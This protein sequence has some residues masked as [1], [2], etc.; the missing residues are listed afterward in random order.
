MKRAQTLVA[1]AILLAGCAA[2]AQTETASPPPTQVPVE[3][4]TPTSVPVVVATEPALAATP[5]ATEVEL[6]PSP[7]PTPMLNDQNPAVVSEAGT[8]LQPVGRIAPFAHSRWSSVFVPNPN[9]TEIFSTYEP[10]TPS[11]DL[12]VQLAQDGPTIC[13]GAAQ[14]ALGVLSPDN[15]TV[16]P[17]EPAG[18]LPLNVTSV[19]TGPDG[20]ALLWSDCGDTSGLAIAD[21]ADD[22]DFSN[23]RIID[24]A[25]TMSVLGR[26]EWII[27][28]TEAFG[29]GTYLVLPQ[30]AVRAPA[31]PGVRHI[32]IHVESGT[33]VDD[34]P[35]DWVTTTGRYGQV[36][37]TA[38]YEV[39]IGGEPVEA[40]TGPTYRAIGEPWP[41]ER[42]RV[43]LFGPNGAAMMTANRWDDDDLV[44]SA[45][46]I[47][48]MTDFVWSPFG[49]TFFVSSP[50]GTWLNG[51]DLML[52]AGGGLQMS[53]DGSTL[54]V[55]A[56]DGWH[57]LTFERLDLSDDADYE[58][59]ITPWT[60]LTSA[61]LGP[62]RIDMTVSE[63]ADVFGRELT[64]DA[65]GD[66][67]R[68]DE[69]VWVVEEVHPGVRILGSSTGDDAVITLIYASGPWLT[70]SGIQIGMTR[71]QVMETFPDQI[72]AR[73]HEYINGEY[74]TF[75]P[76]DP[77][78]PN[79]VQFVTGEDDRV[80]EIKVG[81]RGW[82][83]AVE[84]CA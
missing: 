40:V 48:S 2:V 19:E 49:E 80:Y 59:F 69:C 60:P 11:G 65:I 23:V 34:Q 76:A 52:D 28:T 72:A 70:P 17:A 45:F 15:L 21:L 84:G 79:T 81:Y 10:L 18:E 61:G 7:T 74:L 41:G 38:D 68:V 32:Y 25:Q 46:G 71:D 1:L 42:Q 27:G 5:T 44:V 77:G 14:T 26:P 9:E 24:L 73:P 20:V 29:R 67:T 43:A 39:T 50:D 16:R 75:I 63:L 56:G 8:V 51:D 57:F 4:P 55:T 6:A 78:D 35:G 54:V 3:V 66:P 37:I 82:V 62:I 12:W 31:E 36:Q 33:V 58:R 53:D 83:P 47:E 64:I 13:E 22:G 30:R